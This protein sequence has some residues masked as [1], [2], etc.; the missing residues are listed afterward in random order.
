MTHKIKECR[1]LCSQLVTVLYED[2]SW[3]THHATANLEEI[4]YTTATLLS[5]NNV[6]SGLPISFHAKGQDLYGVVESS[7][8]DA[9]LG[10]FITIKL[11]PF[12]RWHGRLFVPEHFLALCASAI[13]DVTE[14]IT[15][16]AR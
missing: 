4:S 2:H 7:E 12:S 16:R 11:D 8:L 6:E 14:V 9:T 1:Y 5:E 3:K 13:S 15:I 10:W